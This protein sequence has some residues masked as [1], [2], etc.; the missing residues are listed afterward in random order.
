M[1]LTPQ[2]SPK[3]FLKSISLRYLSSH[4]SSEFSLSN[5]I[6]MRLSLY[7]PILPPI[8]WPIKILRPGFRIFSHNII[9][10]PVRTTP[11]YVGFGRLTDTRGG[12]NR[13]VQHARFSVLSGPEVRKW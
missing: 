1:V 5:L 10:P 7:Q 11:G 12:C 8:R 3:L 4:S 6:P 13:S 2:H 9:A